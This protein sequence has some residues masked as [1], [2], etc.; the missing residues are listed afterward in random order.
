MRHKEFDRQEALF[1][2]MKVFW[3]KGFEA[4]SLPDL[5]R[6]MGISRSSLYETFKDKETL[7]EE[8][9]D[10]YQRMGREKF[11]AL[12]AAP[13][14]K[15]GLRDFFKRV[16]DN[17]VSPENPGGCFMVNTVVS[18]SNLDPKI[19]K[20]M[21]ESFGVMHQRMVDLIKHGQSKGEISKSKDVHAL[22]GVIISTIM[23]INVISRIKKDR[24]F[25][26]TMVQGALSAF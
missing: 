14:V 2:A 9:M 26:E 20:R 25:L 4:T 21:Q 13:S 15:E 5:T 1:A 8:A 18:A 6:A 23:G 17:C 7:F 24:A 12:M 16:I 3:E 22:A 10:N 19:A 11:Q